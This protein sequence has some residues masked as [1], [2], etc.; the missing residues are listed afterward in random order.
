MKSSI[1]TEPGLFARTVLM[2]GS[3]LA[4]GAI[5]PDPE[6]YARQLGLRLDCT[7]LVS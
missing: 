4:P 5:V 6:Y 1:S 7:N 2:G 3:A